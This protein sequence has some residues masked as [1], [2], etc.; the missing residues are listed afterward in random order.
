MQRLIW[1]SVWGLCKCKPR[2]DQEIGK[3]KNNNSLQSVMFSVDAHFHNII[4]AV[5]IVYCLKYIFHCVIY[6]FLYIVFMGVTL[7]ICNEI[8]KIQE[9]L[10]MSTDPLST[11]HPA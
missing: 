5:L 10:V 7:F 3:D 4:P 11:V 6:I 2:H 9:M 8:V 1:W